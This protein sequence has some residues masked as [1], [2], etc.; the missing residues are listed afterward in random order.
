MQTIFCN[1]QT[2]KKSNNNGRKV[3]KYLMS[4]VQPLIN[5]ILE[6]DKSLTE[7]LICVKL[8][9]NEGYISQQRSRE[10]KLK[11]PQVTQKFFNQLKTL[12]N[13]KKTSGTPTDAKITEDSL[14]EALA[15]IKQQNEYLQKVIDTNLAELSR[16]VN[17]N[18]SAIRA[19]VRGY[20]KYQIL[21]QSNWDDQ[22]FLKAMA[23]VDKIYGE[24]LRVDDGQG[25]PRT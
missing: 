11:K 25:N 20:G 10:K 24:E 1:M 18:T 13:A 5:S 19:E 22:E 15:I 2:L 8:G 16:D 21:K 9:Y 7:E 12:Q 4:E 3:E 14:S 23:V 17:N 6:R